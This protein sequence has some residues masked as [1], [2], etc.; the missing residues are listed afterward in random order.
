M[1]IE[2][3]RMFTERKQIIEVPASAVEETLFACDACSHTD[4]T[5]RDIEI[6]YAEN[7]AC[8]E[9]VEYGS[10]TLY[11]F[12]TSDDMKIWSANNTSYDQVHPGFVVPGWY[13]G[14]SY[15]R[16]CG[17]GCCY[18]D[19]LDLTS[20]DKYIASEKAAIRDRAADL[21]DLKQRFGPK[22]SA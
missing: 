22:P 3:L 14:V 18:K 1:V 13:V 7:H 12:E 2:W 6:H 19:H 11:R 4:E 20:I 9:A 17:K 16:P 5:K 10:L 8:K 21:R 15:E